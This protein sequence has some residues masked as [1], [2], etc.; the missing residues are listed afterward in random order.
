MTDTF[1]CGSAIRCG[2]YI[3]TCVQSADWSTEIG[4]LVPYIYYTESYSMRPFRVDFVYRD[5]WEESKAL[6]EYLHAMQAILYTQDGSQGAEDGHHPNGMDL[7]LSQTY[8]LRVQF[9]SS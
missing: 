1:I 2:S 3:H 8:R 5:L 4:V 6:L 7:L 9:V